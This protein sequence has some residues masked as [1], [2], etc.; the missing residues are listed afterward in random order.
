MTNKS[1]FFLMQIF[2]IFYVNFEFLKYLFNH[3]DS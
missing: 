1:N 2:H 3:S